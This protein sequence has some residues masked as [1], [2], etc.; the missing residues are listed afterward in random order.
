MGPLRRQIARV[1]FRG[2]GLTLVGTAVCWAEPIVVKSVRGK[3]EIQK[4]NSQADRWRALK[5]GTPIKPGD[6]VRTGPESRVE[7]KIDDGSRVVLGS[8]SRIQVALSAPSRVFSLAVGRVKAFV[9]KLQPQ[10]K[11]EIKTPLAAAAVR[12]TVFEMGFDEEANEGFLDVDRGVVDLSQEGKTVAVHAGERMGFRHDRPLDD[13]PARRA[14]AAPAG[15]NAIDRAELRREV[16][17]GMSKES[18]MAAAAQEIRTAEYQEGKVLTDVNGNRVRLEEYII[19]NPSEVGANKDRAFKFVVL[20]ERDDRFDYFYYLGVFNKT[21]DDLGTALKDVR[22][23]LN[24]QPDYYLTSYEMGQSNTVDSVKDIGT[25]GHLV[26]V[27]FDGTTYTLSDPDDPT[28]TRAI[29]QETPNGSDYDVYDPVADSVGTFTSA[30]RAAGEGQSAVYDSV[31]DS[32]RAF[33]AG[34]VYYRTAFD[35]YEHRLFGPG[36]AVGGTLKQGVTKKTSVNTVLSATVDTDFAGPMDPDNGLMYRYSLVSQP[37]GS[38]V[39]HNKVEVLYADGT[40]ETVNTYIIS[41][42]GDKA[43][44]SAFNGIVT[45]ADFKNELL[46]WNYQQTIEA[47]E[48][49]GRKIDL[50]VEPKILI[51]AGLIP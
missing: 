42:E 35:S 41:D 28:D 48:F 23:K 30:E 11:F 5:K 46:K 1:L 26:K 12:G 38:D 21:I 27:E 25:D 2:A 49:Q 22:G 10:S 13:R 29:N 36:C 34:D 50:V 40:S 4:S 43:P 45:G 33:E 47:T 20:N 44:L 15:S 37:S 24:V 18:V 17:L 3:A 6:S 32:Y 7:L 19:R 9:K 16:G 14:D 31:Q 8:K 51:R 39:Y